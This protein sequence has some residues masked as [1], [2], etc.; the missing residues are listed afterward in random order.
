[1][2]KMIDDKKDKHELYKQLKLE[3]KNDKCCEINYTL[4]N[5]QYRMKEFMMQFCNE[6]FYDKCIKTYIDHDLKYM[7]NG[8]DWNYN[9]KSVLFVSLDYSQQCKTKGMSYYNLHECDY[10]NN[11]ISDVLC[12]NNE[13]KGKD[14]GIIAMHKAQ[15]GKMKNVLAHNDKVLTKDI[16]VSTVD[17]FQGKE[18]KLII[19]SFVRTDVTSTSFLANE[20]RCNV[21]LTR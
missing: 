18:K 20:Q 7:I 1:M 9:D 2:Q 14:I 16:E 12:R 17:G 4:L 10:I 11:V 21:A 19:L 6:C 13:I 8:I 15:V 3:R 5:V